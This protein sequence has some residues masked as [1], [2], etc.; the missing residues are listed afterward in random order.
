MPDAAWSTVARA[1]AFA[2]ALVVR[3]DGPCPGRAQVVA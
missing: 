3:P 1:V 2:L